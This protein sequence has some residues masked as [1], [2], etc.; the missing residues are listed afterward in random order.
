MSVPA[1][2]EAATDD[3]S[4]ARAGLFASIAIASDGAAA[5]SKG[6]ST[7]ARAEKAAVRKC[8]RVSGVTDCAA[9][10]TFNRGCGAVSATFKSSGGSLGTSVKR[11]KFGQ[12]R[13][14]SAAKRASSFKGSTVIKVTCV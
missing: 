8:S 2:T 12:A 4:A 10:G 13:T 6:A 14:K 9:K 1:A 5:A 7:A 11:S 3:A